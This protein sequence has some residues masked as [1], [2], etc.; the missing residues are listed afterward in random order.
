VNTCP[1]QHH[2]DRQALNIIA[3]NS[4]RP[5][6]PNAACA[7]VVGRTRSTRSCNSLAPTLPWS[8]PAS[9]TPAR[10]NLVQAMKCDP[11]IE[12]LRPH[13]RPLPPPPPPRPLPRASTI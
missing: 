1:K 3:T 4:Q 9:L 2:L 11:I 12:P 13:A 10:G 5:N 6:D 8:A 7:S